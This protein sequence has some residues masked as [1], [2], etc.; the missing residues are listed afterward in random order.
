MLIVRI[1]MGQEVFSSQYRVYYEDTDAGGIVYHANYLKFC[2]RA[3][4]DFVR[5][6]VGY[7]QQEHLDVDRKG[8]VVSKIEA[9]FISSAKLED[10]LTVTVVPQNLRRASLEMYQEIKN[11]DG[12]VLFAQRSLLAHI[13][14][15]TNRPEAIPESFSSIVSQHVPGEDFKSLC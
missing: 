3:R 6:V 10:V 11:K 8:F 5:E 12:K 15:A 4:T 13:N 9:R 14:F 7:N 2:E 1:N